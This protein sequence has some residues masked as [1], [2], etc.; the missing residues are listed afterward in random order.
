MIKK[1]KRQA[2]N[3]GKIFVRHISDKELVFK[4]HKELHTTQ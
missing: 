4:I 2:I 1:E 3:W